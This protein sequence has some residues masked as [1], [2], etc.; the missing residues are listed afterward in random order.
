ML[1]P[2]DKLPWSWWGR[3]VVLLVFAILIGL[4]CYFART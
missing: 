4:I 2:R 3:V 1:A